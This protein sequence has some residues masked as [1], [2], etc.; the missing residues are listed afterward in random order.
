MSVQ[1]ALQQIQ[2]AVIL[3][4]SI[5]VGAGFYWARTVLRSNASVRESSAKAVKDAADAA[6]AEKDMFYD[7]IRETRDEARMLRERD[8]RREDELREAYKQL[9]EYAVTPVM[10]LTGRPEDTE[11]YSALKADAY[12]RKP[13]DVETFIS[14]L[15]LHGLALDRSRTDHI[16]RR[17]D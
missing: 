12:L 11:L 3:G 15:R 13:L 14:A 9:A 8:E 10:V 17:N 6:K 5:L 4:V 16:T 7:M 1:E 2:I